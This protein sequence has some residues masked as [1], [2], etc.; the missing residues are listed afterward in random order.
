M[1]DVPEYVVIGHVTRDV[2]PNGYRIGGTVTYGAVTARNLGLR[3]G[4]VTSVGPELSLAQ[5]LP[6]IEIAGSRAAATSTFENIYDAA[7]N[8]QQFI[9]GVADRITISDVPESWHN[10][11]IIHL[12]PL[13]QEMGHEMVDHFPNSL[14]GIT[15][16]G[17]MRHW[18]LDGKISP[19]EWDEEAARHVLA[20]ADALIFSE[21]DLGGD[22]GRIA[23]LVAEAH[24]AV[25]TQS[26][27]GATIYIRGARPR[28]FPAFETTEV[29]P[30]GAGDVFAAAFLIE[31]KRSGDPYRA[32]RFANCVASFAVEQPGILGIPSMEQ[33]QERLARRHERIGM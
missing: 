3:A 29:E 1:I 22:K 6:G 11:P 16:Q 25:V 28:H 24:L 30:T 2:V 19:V 32:V 27:R 31:Y 8:R 15:P 23:H 9:R 20:R 18:D 17:W 4:I 5:E 13:T 12:G 33:V 7:G 14:I 26:K 21:M 10:A